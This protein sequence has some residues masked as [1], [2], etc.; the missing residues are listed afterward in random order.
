M[1]PGVTY[2]PAASMI[3]IVDGAATFA[4]NAT[5]FPSFTYKLP[6]SIRP[7][8]AV[9]KMAFWMTNSFLPL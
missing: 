8:V 1:I 9:S 5:I 7:C 2:F 4:P 6:F 3:V